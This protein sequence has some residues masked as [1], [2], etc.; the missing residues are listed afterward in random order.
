MTVPLITSCGAATS[1]SGAERPPI[2]PASTGELTIDLGLGTGWAI[3]LAVAEYVIRRRTSRT[4]TQ[5][6]P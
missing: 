5:V 2:S 6:A 3:N 1:T 4:R